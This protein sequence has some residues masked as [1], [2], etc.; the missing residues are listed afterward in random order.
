MSEERSTY[1]VNST[2]ANLDAFRNR[3]CTLL[4]SDPDYVPPEPEEVDALIKL[5]GWS[6]NDTAKLVGVNY[7]PKKGSPTVRRWRA[8][9]ASESYREIPYAAW[10]LMLFYA[11]VVTVKEDLDTLSFQAREDR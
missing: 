9:K 10:R 8:N 1:R 2:P 3:P 4:C 6:Q 11:G 5:S 7:N